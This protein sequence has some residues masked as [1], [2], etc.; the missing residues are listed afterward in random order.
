MTPGKATS[1]LLYSRTISNHISTINTNLVNI[2][3]VYGSSYK[4]AKLIVAKKIVTWDGDKKIE[5]NEEGNL[6][7]SEVKFN[8]PSRPD[9]KVLKGVTIEVRTNQIIALVG[10]SGCGK[11]SIVSLLERFY[12]PVEGK[13]LFNNIDL[14]EI[15]NEWY[16]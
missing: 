8:Y 5:N 16:H 9:V 14:K 1:V 4:V 11:S 7:L 12:D 2:S 6:D 10:S 15:E 3:K 13:V